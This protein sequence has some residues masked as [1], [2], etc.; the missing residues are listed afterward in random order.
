MKQRL[1]SGESLQQVAKSLGTNES[2][3][4]KQL[5]AVSTCDC[6]RSLRLWCIRGTSGRAL[7]KKKYLQK[8]H[9]IHNILRAYEVRQLIS[10]VIPFTDLAVDYKSM[11]IK[12][13]ALNLANDIF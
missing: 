9:F 4:Q 10:S 2:N 6:T 7:K 13:S 5:K 3:L 12:L 1:A 8:S 11:V